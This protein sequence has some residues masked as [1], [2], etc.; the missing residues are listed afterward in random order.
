MCRPHALPMIVGVVLA[1][2]AVSTRLIIPLFTRQ[3][4]DNV[5]RAGE[6]WLLPRL[7]VSIFALVLLRSAATYVRGILLE[8]VSQSAIFDLRTGL[9]R[10]LSEMPFRFYDQHRIGEIMSRMT[11]DIEGLRNLLAGGF[12][13]LLE[14]FV[15]FFGSIVFLFTLNVKLT[16]CLI[17]FAPLVAYIAYK[18]HKVIRPAFSEIRE[19]NAVLNTR[20]QENIAGVR[21]VKAFANEEYEKEAF[22]KDNE[23]Q[24]N[25]NLRATWIATNY[26]PVL[27]LIGSL[28][29]PMLLI[30]GGF[31]VTRGEIT[32]GTLVAFN[33]YIW[34]LNGPMRNLGGMINQLAQA[35]ASADKLFYY[36]DL[37]ASIRDKPDAVDPGREAF[38]GHVRFEDVSFSYGDSPVLQHIDI[39]LAPGKTL[40]I[41]GATG[42]G[43][44]TVCSLMARFYDVSS[45][46]V[47]V[48]GIDVRDWKLK[49]LRSRIGF[50]MQETFLFSETLD[51]NVLFGCPDAPLSHAE[52]A[53][54]MAQGMEFVTHMPHGWDTV[55]GERGL[56]LS[57]GQKQRV[58]IA[59]ALA[60]EPGILVLDDATSAVDMETEHEI[61]RQL[62]S[63]MKDRTTIVIAHRISSVKNADEI[64][65][66]EEGRIA[67]RGNHQSLMKA[68]GLYYQMVQDQYKDFTA[69]LEGQVG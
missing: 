25:L 1:L 48:D 21:V 27:D 38:R 36:M 49:A 28:C 13:N 61:Q 59:R 53:M 23:K 10:H 54:T 66:L 60:I 62:H 5:V 24:R 29:T 30:V 50:V 2:A 12:L 52:D 56:G 55:V 64:V 15:Y 67:E 18:Y 20:T 47:S 33:G 19:Q 42:A 32:L 44:T 31:M 9:Y 51:Q 11:G 37:G 35:S 39:D 63:F 17:V 8:G 43:K 40:A 69:S 45:G 41:M 7:L 6:T 22:R 57:G 46:R 4:V 26:N 14:N 16:L 58:A 3:V 65:V 34:M 68:R